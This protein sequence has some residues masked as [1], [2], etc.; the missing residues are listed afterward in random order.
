MAVQDVRVELN[1]AKYNQLIGKITDLAGKLTNM[2]PV[3]DKFED[4]YKTEITPAAFETRGKIFGAKWASYSSGYLKWKQKHASGKQMLV[5]SGKMK[6]AA[7]GGVGWFT[8]KRKNSMIIGIKGERYYN[9]HQFGSKK[10]NIPAR[11]FLFG[12]GGRMPAKALQKLINLMRV[13][14]NKGWK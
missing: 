10:R 4:F 7:T 14:I 8:K 13:E 12:P 6:T 3:W 11:P 1:Q 5:L 2:K 9:A